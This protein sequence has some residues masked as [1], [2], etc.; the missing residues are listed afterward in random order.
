MNHFQT[1]TAAPAA[2]DPRSPGRP[3]DPDTQTLYQVELA[4]A[5]LQLIQACSSWIC[6]LGPSPDIHARLVHLEQQLAG[7]RPSQ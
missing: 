6:R 4:A 1:R 7:A 2:T 3:N 5:D